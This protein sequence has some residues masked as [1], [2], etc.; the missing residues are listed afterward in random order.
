L[1]NMILANSSC[2]WLPMWRRHKIDWAGYKILLQ[3]Q[4]EWDNI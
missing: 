2:G 3:A 1:K 4:Q